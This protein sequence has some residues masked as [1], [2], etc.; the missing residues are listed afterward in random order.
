MSNSGALLR[1]H[2]PNCT[3][4]NWE[5]NLSPVATFH[6]HPEGAAQLHPHVCTLPMQVPAYPSTASPALLSSTHSHHRDPAVSFSLPSLVTVS[7]RF[8]P[9]AFLLSPLV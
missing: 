4:T 1:L 9:C 7:S 8:S 6:S 5:G 3:M 2:E